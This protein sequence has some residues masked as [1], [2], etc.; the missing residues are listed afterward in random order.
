MVKKDVDLSCFAENSDKFIRFYGHIAELK[1]L[2]RQGW[3]RRHG[4]EVAK[5]ES[6]AD[7]IFSTMLMAMLIAKE[8]RPDLNAQNIA[9]ML[10]IHDLAESLTGDFMPSENMSKKQKSADEL[11]SLEKIFEKFSSR[12]YFV[13][14][15]KEYEA[16][17]TVE[18]QFAK[19]LDKLDAALMAYAYSHNGLSSDG[20]KEF[21]S[22]ASKHIKSDEATKLLKELMSTTQ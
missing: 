9:I 14:L 19:E 1:I 4:V 13:D 15:W 18:S 8:L 3:V 22:T 17:V 16:Q 20:L 6:V 10:L 2:L 12:E 5:A 11:A 21:Y 7:H